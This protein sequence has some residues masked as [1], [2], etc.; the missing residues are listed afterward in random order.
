MRQGIEQ[1]LFLMCEE[2]TYVICREH[3]ASRKIIKYVYEH[4]QS[5][6]TVEALYY[7]V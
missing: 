5:Y 3:I 6:R 1:Q 7:A 4:G 2:A